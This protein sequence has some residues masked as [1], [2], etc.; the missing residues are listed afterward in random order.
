MD[1]QQLRDLIRRVLK[2]ANLIKYEDEREIEL[3]LLTAAT[4][5][6]L[7]QYIRQKGGGPA[8]G[9]FQMEPGTYD[10]IWENYI[11]YRE[12]LG[13]LLSFCRMGE[14]HEL[15]FNLAYAILMCR[16][17]YLRVKENI[18]SANDIEG[19]ANYWKENYNS[20]LGKGKVSEAIKKYN[21]YVK[22]K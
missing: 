16:I 15:E 17:H 14:A 13:K 12:D 22:C 19:L 5:S 18:P 20:Y 3:L 11:R 10:D 9:I 6:N 1:S 21:K 2:H 7:G 4:E 8:L